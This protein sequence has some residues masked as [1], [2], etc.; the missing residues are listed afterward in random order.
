M[1]AAQPFFKRG[2]SL[3]LRL[4]FFVLLSLILMVVDTHFKYLYE[5]RQTIA[6]VISPVQRLA[7]IPKKISDLVNDFFV[8]QNLADE[9]LRLK[10]QHLVDSGKLQQFLALMAENEHL[11]KLLET[12]QRN[13]SKTIVAEIISVPPDPFSRRVTLDKGI[14]NGIQL[15][16]V[17]IDNLGVVGQITRIYPWSSEVTLITDREH[18]VPVQ[19]VRNGIRSVV[20]GT[21]KDKT[22]ELQYMANNADIQNGDSLVTSGIDGTYPSGLPVALVSKIKRDASSAFASIFCTPVAGV[23]RNKQVLILFPR[24][25]PET[26]VESIDV[27]SKDKGLEESGAP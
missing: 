7:Y 5:V 21:G 17:V 23:D 2:P 14:K 22:L 20:F 16:Q 10:Q 18:S 25:N 3:L 26:P 24:T 11:R 12:S 4:V 6:V 1:E 13:K 15:G 8:A 9:N 19:I 27:Q